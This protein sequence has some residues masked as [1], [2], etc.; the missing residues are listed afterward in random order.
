MV[1]L[2]STSPAGLAAMAPPPGCQGAPWGRGA[3]EL[4]SRCAVRDSNFQDEGTRG[5]CPAGVDGSYTLVP[6]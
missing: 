1:E 4:W 2:L 5:T 3:D 6:K